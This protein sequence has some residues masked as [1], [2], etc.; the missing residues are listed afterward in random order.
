MKTIDLVE[1]EKVAKAHKSPFRS[2]EWRE[3]AC[4]WGAA[5]VNVK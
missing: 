1:F 2:F 3:F 5:F 4:G